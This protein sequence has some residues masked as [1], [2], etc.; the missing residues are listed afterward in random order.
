MPRIVLHL[1][2]TFVL[3]LGAAPA[4]ASIEGLWWD[5]SV[6]G[7]GWTFESQNDLAAITWYRYEDGQP[8]FRTILANVTYGTAMDGGQQTL[9]FQMAGRVYRTTNNTENVDGFMRGVVSAEGQTRV[10]VPF[11][12]NYANQLEFYRGIWNVSN[13]AIPGV[14]SGAAL[15]F[16]N[17]QTQLLSDGT[18]AR[19]FVTSDGSE[20]FVIYDEELRTSIFIAYD[21]NGGFMG[22]Y[23][24]AN[25]KVGV[26][27]GAFFDSAGN[28]VTDF[29]PMVA[30]AIANSD[31][32]MDALL[33]ILGV[34][35]SKSS[36]AR[37]RDVAPVNHATG[38]LAGRLSARATPAQ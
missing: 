19:E 23:L 13:L 1:V 22:G 29:F 11:I 38:I 35:V 20:G 18:P 16:F 12:Y 30:T 24:G 34:S 33:P 25:N 28:Q 14:T 6:N 8:A 31:G 5:P 10:V 4:V 27:E 15:V 21:G 37:I 36:Q 9:Q 26:G 3:A 7:E 32:E 17:P 2:C